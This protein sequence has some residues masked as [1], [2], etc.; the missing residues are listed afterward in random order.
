[1]REDMSMPIWV[2]RRLNHDTMKNYIF[3]YSK[4]LP[5]GHYEKDEF[6][7]DVI[8]YSVMDLIYSWDMEVDEDFDEI[9]NILY[10]YFYD[11]YYN[12]IGK[13]YDKREHLRKI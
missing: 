4:Q 2:K 7:D 11:K 8:R 10:D 12:E 1:M 3:G 6:I 9:H 5:Q 13:I